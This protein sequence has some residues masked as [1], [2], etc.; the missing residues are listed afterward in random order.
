MQVEA[1]LLW[2]RHKNKHITCYLARE[3]G[4]R[5]G[6]GRDTVPI[7]I[8]VPVYMN[9]ILTSTVPLERACSTA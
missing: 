2:W 1:A 4:G 9:S 7:G 5:G 8:H 6:G 3:E